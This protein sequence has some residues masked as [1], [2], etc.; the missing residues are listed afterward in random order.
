MELSAQE[1]ESI[2]VK[3][4]NFFF[5]YFKKVVLKQIEITEDKFTLG[6]FPYWEDESKFTSQVSNEYQLIIH[7]IEVGQEESIKGRIAFTPSIY[8]NIREEYGIPL[9]FNFTAA[10]CYPEDYITIEDEMDFEKIKK[11]S[12]D[13][14]NFYEQAQVD[15]ANELIE[16]FYTVLF[17]NQPKNLTD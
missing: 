17:F 11:F 1:A 3:L 16:N 5:D 13:F 15:K 2:K 14:N 8:Q 10:T 9:T 12:I 6:S 7:E 4:S